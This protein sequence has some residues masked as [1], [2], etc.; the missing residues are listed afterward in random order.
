MLGGRGQ[1]GQATVEWVGLL[2]AV[3]LMLGALAGGVRGA[4]R[5]DSG[6]GA[7]ELGE[8]VAKRISCAARDLCGAA[9]PVRGERGS[10]RE[11]TLLSGGV[12]HREAAPGGERRASPVPP[13]RSGPLPNLGRAGSV[14]EHAWIACLGY[15]SLRDD[16][17]HPRSPREA[18]PVERTLDIVNECLNPWEFFFGD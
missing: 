14:A 11:G 1:K 3:G 15:R 4:T 13:P 18:R 7:R 12:P 2:L 17:E 10:P 5:A 8:A 6:E 16:L 9:A